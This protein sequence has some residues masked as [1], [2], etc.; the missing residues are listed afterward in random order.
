MNLDNIVE[1]KLTRTEVLDILIHE[2]SDDLQAALRGLEESV[3]ALETFTWEEVAHLFIH[4]NV[5]EVSVNRYSRKEEK[6]R[7]EVT[8]ELPMSSPKVGA[9]L[10]RHLEELA[11]MEK[12]KGD[13][14]AQLQS[15]YGERGA[16]KVK[17]LRQMLSQSV[18]G[19][20]LIE[21]LDG[22]KT[23]ARKQLALRAKGGEE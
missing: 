11:A 10:R 20:K 19:R 22:M 7:I 12:D 15:I 4:G 8:L 6:L 17:L 23:A 3:K 16:L 5:K 13:A 18:D 9:G 2:M 14:R 1:T 21:M